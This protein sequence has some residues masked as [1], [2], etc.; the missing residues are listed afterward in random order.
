[1]NNSPPQTPQRS[2]RSTAPARQASPG[3][4]SLNSQLESSPS[5]GVSAKNRSG[6]PAHESALPPT[7]PAGT[8][9]PA[10]AAGLGRRATGAELI[11]VTRMKSASAATTSSMTA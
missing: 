5:S 6:S 7:G 1:M 3:G 9:G 2:L 4:E 8:A 10:G 11:A